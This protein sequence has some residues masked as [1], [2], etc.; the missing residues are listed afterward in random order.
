MPRDASHGNR[1]IQCRHK[2]RESDQISVDYDPSI[3]MDTLVSLFHCWRKSNELSRKRPCLGLGVRDILRTALQDVAAAIANEQKKRRSRTRGSARW[4]GIKGEVQ[5]VLHQY[6]VGQGVHIRCAVTPTLSALRQ[7]AYLHAPA[8][9]AYG[10]CFPLLPRIRSGRSTPA[11]AF[12]LWLPDGRDQ[13]FA[14]RSGSEE[15]QA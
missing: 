12:K 3:Y 2:S 13:Q 5:Y 6:D 9:S 7:R 10:R 11:A 1:P 14:S 8:R 4:M 15:L